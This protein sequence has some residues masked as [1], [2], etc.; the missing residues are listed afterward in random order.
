MSS[1]STP[2]GVVE[3][4][5]GLGSHAVGE[6]FD[7][8]ELLCFQPPRCRRERHLLVGGD[9]AA[10]G[11]L[12]VE[13]ARPEHRS[14]G[15]EAT[16]GGATD[17]GPIADRPPRGLL[18]GAPLLERHPALRHLAARDPFAQRANPQH[19][20]E[21]PL[22]HGRSPSN[23]ASRSN[24]IGAVV[25]IV[26]MLS[27]VVLDR[28]PESDRTIHERVGTRDVRPDLDQ[29]ARFGVCGEQS[30]EFLSEPAAARA[31]SPNRRRG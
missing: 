22:V 27:E 26:D 3:R 15:D 17:R 19:R 8:V 11:G 24:A 6:S 16:S 12:R 21:T 10:A 1:I 25:A 14:V 13:D 20:C 9:D 4:R 31:S 2:F 5:S 7:A 23:P 18:D 30:A 28:P 29:V